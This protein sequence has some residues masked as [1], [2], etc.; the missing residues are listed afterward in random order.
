MPPTV[1]LLM[2]VI[3]LLPSTVAMGASL[4]VLSRAFGQESELPAVEVGRLYAANT[5]GAV[6]GPLLAV[7]WLFPA[8]GLSRS[9]LLAALADLLVFAGLLLARKVFPPWEG[10]PPAGEVPKE[11]PASENRPSL[12]L[13]IA[14]GVSGATAMVYEVAWARTLSMVYGSSVYGVSIMLSTFLLGIA[15]GSALA[16]AILRWRARRATISTVAWLLAGSAGGAFLSLIVARGLPFFF[17][18]LY[19]SFPE[20]DTTL[21]VAQ[22]VVSVL[23]MLPVT[24]CL[25]AMLPVTTSVSTSK[26]LELGRQ[27]SWLYTA[28]L[29][30]SAAGAILAAALLVGSLGIELSVRLASATALAVALILVTRSRVRR[31]SALG[32]GTLAGAILFVVG[33]DPSGEPVAKGFGFYTDPRAYDRY[34]LPGLRQIVESHQLLYYRD[35]PTATVAVQWVEKYLFL[36]INGKTDAS[37]GPGDIDTQ[38]LLGHLPLMV[39]DAKRVAI[40]GWGS[41]MTGGAVLSHDVDEVDAFEIEPAVIEASRFFHPEEDNPL[42]DSRLRMVVGDAR[43]LMHKDQKRYDLII[44]EPSNPWLTG[45]ANLFTKDF[46]ELAASRLEPGGILCQWFHLYGMSEAST[47]SLLATFKSVFPHALAFKDRDL[48]L[49]GSQEPL[50]FDIERMNQLFDEPSIRESLS[51]SYVNY[52][53]DLLADL[54]LDEKGIETYAKGAPLNTDDNLLLE[55]AAPRSLYQDNVEAIRAGM[56]SHSRSIL[57]HLSNEGSQ[58][59]VYLELASSF[60]TSKRMDEALATCQRALNLDASFEGWKLLGLIHQSRGE[61]DD[62][63]TAWE[64]ALAMEALPKD[65]RFVQAALR[66][67]DSPPSP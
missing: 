56:D 63:R 3:V 54:R 12:W 37:N 17:V 20:R 48:I 27:V 46:F 23:L 19:R 26:R 45:V 10:H 9:L 47:R 55:L 43:S 4:P 21:F 31:F 64:T 38:L 28:N 33:I 35:G 5:A 32:V 41:G 66:S 62:A 59:E 60:F 34:D 51:L 49:L 15:A 42:D 44:S 39:T 13:L 1:Q 29:L 58:T 53:F 8:L 25:G 14:M 18:N 65:K 7:F 16:A 67:L 22:F 61:L 40:I 30:G 52:P 57:D 36:K 6:A 50:R 11:S 24:C 2:A